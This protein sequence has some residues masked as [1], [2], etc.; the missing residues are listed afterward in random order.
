MDGLIDV[1]NISKT[2]IKKKYSTPKEL[3]RK[4]YKRQEYFIDANIINFGEIYP[5]FGG[6]P[7]PSIIQE[8]QTFIALSKPPKIHCHP[9]SY[10]EKDNLLSFLYQEKNDASLCVNTGY[11]DRGLIY[12]I[13]YETS[14]LVLY[15][16]SDEL[17][18]KY[19]ENFKELVIEK[20]Y[21]AIVDGEYS[22]STEKLE[23]YLDYT[24]SRNGRAKV[25]PKGESS[26]FLA[27]ASVEVIEYN[28]AQNCS[29]LLLTLKQGHRHQLRVQLSATGHAIL[30]DP[31]YG[32]RAE[33]RMFLHCYKYT[34]I[35]EEKKQEY[36]DS[37][38]GLF[39]DFFNFNG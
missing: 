37:N 9:L 3:K 2:Q 33:S 25:L 7:R 38:L 18:H 30:G 21:F 11:Y 34:L 1:L 24:G 13:D 5:E 32:T 12:R 4:I 15:A 22:S 17:Y 20:Q 26:A 23:H 16:K 14:G 19:R 6:G 39:T 31:L 36:S 10:D 27:Q 29:L 28:Q 35:V 8:D